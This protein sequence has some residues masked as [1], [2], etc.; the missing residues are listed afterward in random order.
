MVFT[1]QKSRAGS[2]SEYPPITQ[3]GTNICEVHTPSQTVFTQEQ[4]ELFVHRVVQY[5]QENESDEFHYYV[6]GLNESSTE[7]D[8]T[9]A[10]LNL[11][12]RFHPDKNN[13]LLASDLAC[14]I[15]EAEEEL[16]GILRH[17]DAMREQ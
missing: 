16:E 14:I 15:N 8:I 11:A 13:H 9:K 17:N 10:F 6:L 5:Y 1:R 7:D 12:C 2:N 4:D 3:P